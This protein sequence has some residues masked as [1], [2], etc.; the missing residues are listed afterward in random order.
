MADQQFADF[1]PG[2]HELTING[3]TSDP[4]LGWVMTV[5]FNMISTCP[6]LVVPAGIGTNGVPIGMQIVG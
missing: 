5:P 1:D 2:N 6:V 3:K 4:M